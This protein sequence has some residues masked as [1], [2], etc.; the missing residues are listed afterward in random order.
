MVLS[1]VSTLIIM[2]LAYLVLGCEAWL[3]SS[4]QLLRSS[5]LVASNTKVLGKERQFND[6]LMDSSVLQITCGIKSE[7][8]LTFFYCLHQDNLGQRGICNALLNPH[9]MLQQL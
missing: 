3:I 8:K 2:S 9:L 5:G 7:H 6:N 4:A 1:M